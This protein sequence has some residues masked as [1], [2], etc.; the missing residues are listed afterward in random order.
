[1]VSSLSCS[2]ER[3]IVPTDAAVC[4]FDSEFTSTQTQSL[5]PGLTFA[6]E[7]MKES[8]ISLSHFYILVAASQ[9]S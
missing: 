9:R 4:H 8:P 3:H 2:K 7:G 6:T 5:Q 1:M